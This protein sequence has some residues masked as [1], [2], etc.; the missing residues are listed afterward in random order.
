MSLF[1][2]HPASWSDEK[3]LEHCVVERVRRSG[4]GGQHRNKVETGIVL[5]FQPTGCVAQAGEER[6]QSENLANAVK[7]LRVTLA[8][9]YRL[10]YEKGS[11]PAPSELWKTR[12][13]HGKLSINTQHMDYV[14]LLAELMDMLECYDWEIRDVA[15][16]CAVSQSQI[17]KFLKQ[18][19][20]AAQFFQQQRIAHGLHPL[21]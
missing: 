13:R 10:N 17:L 12:T 19:P 15:E 2:S 8:L 11:V 5:S 4:P 21:K 16:H 7:R 6:S 14:V 9:V 1:A 20:R 18:E 3:L